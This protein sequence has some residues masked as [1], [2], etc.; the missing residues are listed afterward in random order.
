MTFKCAIANIPYVGAK[1][2]IMCDPKKMS[3]GELER[4]TRAYTTAMADV[5]GVLIDRQDG[6]FVV[7]EDVMKSGSFLRSLSL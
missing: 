6:D 5:F 3:V 1:G 7:G 4:L 2:G